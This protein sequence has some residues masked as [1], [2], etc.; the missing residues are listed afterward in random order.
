MLRAAADCSTRCARERHASTRRER[1]VLRLL[2]GGLTN[3]Q[4]AERRRQRAHRPPP[5]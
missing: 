2:A 5:L 4:I 3:R 1:D